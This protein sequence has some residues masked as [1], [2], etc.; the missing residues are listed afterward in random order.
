MAEEGGNTFGN[1]V[2]AIRV[3][4]G[5]ILAVA[6]CSVC[7]EDVGT[8]AYGNIVISEGTLSLCRRSGKAGI[9][10]EVDVA[11]LGP[12]VI[13]AERGPVSRGGC[14]VG[15]IV[16]KDDLIDH[17]SLGGIT[18]RVEPGVGPE[19]GDGGVVDL[20]VEEAV[21]GVGLGLAGILHDIEPY[22]GVRGLVDGLNLRAGCAGC[23][24][25]YCDDE[26]LF[27]NVLCV[28]VFVTCFCFCNPGQGQ[29]PRVKDRIRYSAR[30]PQPRPKPLR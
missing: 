6:V 25:G 30:F 27:H 28:C 7:H 21:V 9:G 5:G 16:G 29:P 4:G 1:P 19:V 20:L 2:L 15:I 17:E 11:G 26:I 14:R 18:F 13:T 12:I 24:G 23:Q 22:E 8:G 10:E 3:G